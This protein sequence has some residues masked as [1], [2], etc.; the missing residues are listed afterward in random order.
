MERTHVELTVTLNKAPEEDRVRRE[1]GIAPGWPADDGWELGGGY[2]LWNCDGKWVI[3]YPIWN[4]EED[5]L[6]VDK[7]MQLV[8]DFNRTIAL[9]CF[10]LNV[11]TGPVELQMYKL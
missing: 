1:Y 5:N 8:G 2:Y 3:Q 11:E 4:E 6:P 10:K 7:L 9:A